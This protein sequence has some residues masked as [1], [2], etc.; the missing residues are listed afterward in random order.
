MFD[1][2]RRTATISELLRAI[3][4]A[5]QLQS[6]VPDT[7]GGVGRPT[8]GDLDLPARLTHQ[9]GPGP[10]VWPP[11]TTTPTPP[12]IRSGSTCCT[13][14]CRAKRPRPSEAL[15]CA[16]PS[17]DKSPSAS[18]PELSGPD[19]ASPRSACVRLQRRR[20]RLTL[21]YL[22]VR[23]SRAGTY[24]SIHPSIYLSISR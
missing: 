17:A 24:L 12:S 19:R 21:F 10:T 2:D 18:Q 16:S 6:Q 23:G 1:L 14:A 4:S 7:S 22:L 13:N 20:R 5:Q 11:L 3:P 15:A 9:Y 8:R